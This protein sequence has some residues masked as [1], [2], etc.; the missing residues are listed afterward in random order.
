[1]SEAVGDAVDSVADRAARSDRSAGSGLK[2]SGASAGQRI[3]LAVQGADEAVD[4]LVLQNSG[5]F[6]AAGRHLTDRAVEIDVGNQP[7]IAVLAHQI[8]DLYRLAIRFDD[9]A[10]DHGAGSS[11][12]LVGDL[13]L[14]SGI[15]VETVGIDRRD[16]APKSVDDLLP[17]TLAHLG[18]RGSNRKSRHRRDVEGSANDRLQ[19]HKAPA[20]SESAAVLHRAEQ[21]VVKPLDGS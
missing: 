11:G 20:F 2:R 13:Q 14:L 8:V 16:V 5:E 7:G 9:L 4:T 12:L 15:A 19:L 10:V 17:L 3:G 1:M 6:G 21:G 18:P